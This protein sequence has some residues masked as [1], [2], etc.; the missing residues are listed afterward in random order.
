MSSFGA[1]SQLAHTLD[2]LR[3]VRRQVAAVALL[4]VAAGVWRLSPLHEPEPFTLA[5]IVAG[6]ATLAVELVFA[7]A[8]REE[9]DHY[10][11]ELILA[12]F[13]ETTRQTPIGRAIARRLARLE[14]PRARA[15]LAQGLRWRIR[16][17]NGWTRPSPGYVR[18]TSYPPLTPA[19]RLVFREDSELIAAIAT[20]IEQEPADPRALI[21]AQRLITLP[22]TRD[23]TR[24]VS[25][26]ADDVRTQLETVR[27]LID[28]PPASLTQS[29]SPGE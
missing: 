8:E 26:E 27:I 21:I 28:T 18:A 19:Q 14:T 2:L 20:R 10:A 9:A 11:D 15:A 13:C 1:A 7:W 25:R 12:G 6:S 3:T 22:Q 5:T 4:V 16:L 29:S 23:P 24:R 17:A